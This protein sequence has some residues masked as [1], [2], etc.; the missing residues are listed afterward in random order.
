MTVF[1]PAELKSIVETSNTIT[2]SVRIKNY[3]LENE[4]FY[5]FCD[6]KN[7]IVFIHRHI[8]MLTLPKTQ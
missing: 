1:T 4:T 3:V 8:L 2:E 5:S 7:L 6:F